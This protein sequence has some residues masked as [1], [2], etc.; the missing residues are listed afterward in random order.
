[1][2]SEC[3]LC[4]I[5]YMHSQFEHASGDRHFRKNGPCSKSNSVTLMIGDA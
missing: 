4:C 3:N 1:M 2:K 5:R